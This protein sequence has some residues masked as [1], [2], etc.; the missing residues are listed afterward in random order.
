METRPA[1]VTQKGWLRISDNAD[2]LGWVKPEGRYYKNKKHYGD[3]S[4]VDSTKVTKS[5]L[6][7]KLLQ[8]LFNI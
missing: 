7:M 3:R 5:K 6:K 2:Y 8:Y 1:G 4:W